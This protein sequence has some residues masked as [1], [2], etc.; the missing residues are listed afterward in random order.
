MQLAFAFLCDWGVEW[1][2]LTV[3]ALIGFSLFPVAAGSD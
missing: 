3:S 2:Q 1:W